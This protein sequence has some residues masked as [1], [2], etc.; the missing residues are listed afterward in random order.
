MHE[1]SIALSMIDLAGE[2]AERHPGTRVS[3]LH[4][5]LGPL[6]GVVK[7]ALLFSYE[8]ATAGT[9]LAGS[10]LIIA[11]VPVT[12]YCVACQQER[13]L[14]SLQRFCCPSCGVLSTE[15][16]RGR[17]LEFVALELEEAEP[18]LAGK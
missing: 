3:A 1:L 15:V 8:V 17:E 10:Q 2:E 4:I 7:D 11:D 6:S 12:I 5:K 13:V 18:A 16:V 9:A 14:E